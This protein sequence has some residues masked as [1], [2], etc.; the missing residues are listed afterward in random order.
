MVNVNVGLNTMA[1][2]TIKNIVG[3]AEGSDEVTIT[4]TDGNS[5]VLY[6]EQ[7]CCESVWL[8]DFEGDPEDLSGALIMSAEEVTGV[9]TDEMNEG[10]ECPEW[11]F[12]KIET[13]KGG[14][15]LRWLG[16]SNGYYS[17]SVDFKEI[18]V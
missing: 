9:V 6:H 1:G 16:D 10:T 2:K 3:V 7:D 15:W 13:S 12:Y 5:Y 18:R 4:T 17:T 14:L 11:T 8:Y